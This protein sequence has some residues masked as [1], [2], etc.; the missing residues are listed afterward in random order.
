MITQE[1]RKKV[2]NDLILIAIERG[3]V[4]SGKDTPGGQDSPVVQYRLNFP[5]CSLLISE[6]NGASVSVVE[7]A[8]NYGSTEI[9]IVP[10]GSPFDGFRKLY[11]GS[12]NGIDEIVLEA[13]TSP[14][15]EG[16]T[17]LPSK[18][19]LRGKDELTPNDKSTFDA[20]LMYAQRELKRSK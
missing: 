4:V 17:T 12:A 7:I 5:Y 15:S 2:I 14:T 19:S 18:R 20:F 13:I 9:P 10:A 6:T 16:L 3:E 1:K 8:E 11:Q